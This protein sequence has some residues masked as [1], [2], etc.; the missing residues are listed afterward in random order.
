MAQKFDSPKTESELRLIQ[1]TMFNISAAS[2]EYRR[3]PSFKGLLE[4]I[5][6]DSVILTAIHNIKSNK[7]SQTPGSDKETMKEDILQRDFNL[8]LGRVKE[9]FSNYRPRPLRRVSINKPGKTEKR[10]LGIPSV[11]DRIIQECVRLVLDPILEPQFFQHSYGFRPMRDAHMALARVTDVVHKTGHHWIIEGDISKFFERVNH[12]ILLRKLW[13]MGIHDR[14]V[15]MIIKTMLQAGVIGETGTNDL[16]APQGGIISPLL[17]N[18]YLNSFD[19]WVTREWE[20]KKTQKVYRN[21]KKTV[22]LRESSNLKPAYL[23]RYAD[24]WVLITNSKRNAEKW[25]YR[26][27]KF[28]KGNLKL[29]LSEEKTKITNIKRK[30]IRFLGFE[31]KVTKG[32]SRTGY[33][34]RTKPDRDRIAT[35]VKEIHRDIKHLRAASSMEFLIHDIN[36]VNN[37][38]RGLINYYQAATW[39]NIS[40][41]I[42][43][44]RLKYASYKSLLKF[45]GKWTRANQVNNLISIHE[46]Y[47]EH[48]AAIEYKGLKVGVTSIGFSK[49]NKAMLK[50]P[51]ETPYTPEGRQIYSNRTAKK[52][53]KA[54]ADD[55][56]SEH[57]SM[58]IAT[59][60]NGRLYTF[61][62]YLNRAY[63][64]NRDKGKCR[65][66]RKEVHR[67]DLHF[68]HINKMLPSDLVNKVGNLATM[69]MKCH[70]MIHSKLDYS[71][72]GTKIWK[73]ILSFREKLN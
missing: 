36:L 17:A 58:L 6:S 24:D 20:N 11:I 22:A 38:I 8:V 54:R 25:K 63:A 66:C 72:F 14:R 42:F 65:I 57:L 61:E 41:S 4:I 23:I 16:G 62:Y 33:I 52:P 9:A 53:L 35:K 19:Q 50:K 15:L 71:E 67:Y 29:E 34:T 64:F 48:I 37:K 18:V 27:C 2:Y 44:E 31:Y 13:G 1:D 59:G 60:I 47:T 46:S 10:Q 68:H 30:T 55:T 5:S 3:S 69:H 12:S 32:R 51:S 70:S 39:I 40:L 73:S 56:L 26:I 21:R 43:K 28:L 45:G 7:G 49:W